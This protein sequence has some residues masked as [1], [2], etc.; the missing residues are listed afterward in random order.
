MASVDDGMNAT[1]AFLYGG[2]PFSIAAEPDAKE[3]VVVAG[4]P[5]EDVRHDRMAHR[6]SRLLQNR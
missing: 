6:I 2:E 4:L 1:A 3:H 5:L